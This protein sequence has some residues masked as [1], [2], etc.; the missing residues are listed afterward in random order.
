MSTSELASQK[1][2]IQMGESLGENLV[3]PSSLQ[4]I[5]STQ[6]HAIMAK[7]ST[8]TAVCEVR[9]LSACDIMQFFSDLDTERGPLKP[10]LFAN[11]TVHINN[12]NMNTK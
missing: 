11:C 6:R 8:K 9:E 4:A 10:I 7:P 2:K 12:L 3:P 5:T 1:K